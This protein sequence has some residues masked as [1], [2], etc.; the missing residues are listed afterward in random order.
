MTI[1]EVIYSLLQDSQAVRESL[2][3]RIYPG[4]APESPGFPLAV[5]SDAETVPAMTHDGA[6]TTDLHQ[7]TYEIWALD[8]RSA[9]RAAQAVRGVLNGYR[10]VTHGYRVQGILLG[11]EADQH[12]QPQSAE[13]RGY[14]GVTQNYSVAFRPV[15]QGV[16]HVG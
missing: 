10:G 2:G 4:Q 14:Y 11:S 5:Y 9:K 3:D 1:E 16:N 7:M 8:Y 15:Q 12:E 6:S 13:E